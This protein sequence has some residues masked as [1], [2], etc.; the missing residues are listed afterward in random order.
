MTLAFL[1]AIS[2]KYHRK[3]DG[4]YNDIAC[5]ASSKKGKSNNKRHG[6]A[7]GWGVSMADKLKTAGMKGGSSRYSP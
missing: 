3:F 7:T 6:K 5:C 1:G 4:T 2:I